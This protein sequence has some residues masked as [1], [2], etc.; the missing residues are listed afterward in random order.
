MKNGAG[1]QADEGM[2]NTEKAQFQIQL[3]RL[4]I[5]YCLPPRWTFV[6]V[7]LPFPLSF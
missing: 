7:S 6:F 1:G 5:V 4:K 2:G 3:I